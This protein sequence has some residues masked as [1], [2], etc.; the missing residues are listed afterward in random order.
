MD[1]SGREEL[2]GSNVMRDS[3]GHQALVPGSVGV[4]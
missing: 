2:H 4:F 3:I 1:D